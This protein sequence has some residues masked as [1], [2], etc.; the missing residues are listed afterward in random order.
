MQG[1]L[2]G[3][4]LCTVSIDRL[5]K[6]AYEKPDMLYKYNGIPI[7]PLGMVDEVLTVINVENCLKKLTN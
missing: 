5:G 6:H 1:T 4:L 2:W 7:P 3:S